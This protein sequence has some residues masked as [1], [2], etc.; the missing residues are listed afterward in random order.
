MQDTLSQPLASTGI[1]RPLSGGHGSS[2]ADDSIVRTMGDQ[3]FTNIV[4]ERIAS[5]ACYRRRDRVKPQWIQVHR[6]NRSPTF[7]QLSVRIEGPTAG[8]C[9]DIEHGISQDR[10][11]TRLN[12]SHVRISYAV[13]CLKKK[14]KD[15]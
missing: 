14:I 12:S 10:K 3:L 4:A 5:I 13:F 11:S 8:C 2:I 15:S 9:T 1:D 6:H 7:Y